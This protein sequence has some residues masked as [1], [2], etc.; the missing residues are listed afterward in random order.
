MVVG[1]YGVGKTTLTYGLIGKDMKGIESTDGI[2]LF[3]ARCRI[4]DSNDDTGEWCLVQD[5]FI[6]PAALAAAPNTVLFDRKGKK[7]NFKISDE[8]YDIFKAVTALAEEKQK[9]SFD[10]VSDPNSTTTQTSTS[11]LKPV[12]KSQKTL[13]HNKTNNANNVPCVRP[14]QSSNENEERSKYSSEFY[15]KSQKARTAELEDRMKDIFID[16]WDFGG[17][18]VFYTTHQSF[19]TSRCMY[20]LVINC[21]KDLNAT[22]QDKSLHPTQQSESKIEDF[23]DFW[24]STITNYAKSN[25]SGFPRIILIGTHIDEIVI[26]K[27]A[28]E[29][30][31]RHG[32][33]KIRQVRIMVVGHYG[34]GKTTLTYGL[35]GKDMK[36]IESTDGIDL[37]R[38]R[39][40]IDDSNDDT[41]E[42]CLVQ[43]NFIS[44]AALAAAPNTVLFDRK[45][46]KT[47]FKISDETY[48]IFKAVTALAEEKQKHSFD[49]V[50]D[51][52]STTT[53]TSTSLL[54]PVYKSQKTLMHNKTNNA[55]NVPCVRPDQSSNEN[56]ERSKYS[57]EFYEKSQKARTAELEDR[58]KDIFIDMWDFGGQNVFYTTHQGPVSS[59]VVDLS[60]NLGVLPGLTP[61]FSQA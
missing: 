58:M 47:N 10:N 26:S 29:N 49:N 8:T 54:K 15:E 21:A 46:K 16:M 48:D 60:L 51:P 39:C 36:G 53:Q 56:E 19:L 42:W 20:L 7:T 17:Q 37:F 23:I 22:L 45:G 4:D 57:S 13:M 43:D 18:N 14:D 35:I 1:H 30:E 12:Y 2:D 28:F 5:N 38:A 61:K 40:R 55:N 25:E 32:A 52:N 33:C 44:P 9:H 59:Q 41:G 6:S 50:S 11:L 31:L 3:R 27:E 34:V 24:I